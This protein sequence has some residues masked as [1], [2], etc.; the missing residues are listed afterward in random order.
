MSSADTLVA[1]R[2]R[3][4]QRIAD[5]GMGSVW[6]AW[7]ERLHRRV[8]LKQL[9]PQPGLSPQDASIATERVLREAR[10]TAR[11]HHPNAVPV[12]DVV[13]AD[14]LPCLVMQYLP[15]TSLQALLAARGPLPVAEVARIGADVAAA[16]AAAHRAGIIHRDVKPGNVLIDDSGSAK[17]TDFGIARAL[18]DA[19]LTSTG[20][21]TG[22][23]AYL[24][25]ESARGDQPTFAADVYSLGATLYAAAEGRPPAGDGSNPMA[26]LH[27]VASGR[28]DPPVRSGPLTPLLL[29]M[30]DVD[31]ARRP[32]IDTVA[33]ELGAASAGGSAPTEVPPVPAVPP[34][35]SVA[36]VPATSTMQLPLLG[37]PPAVP[38]PPP[39]RRPARVGRRWWPWLAVSAVL[40]AGL[41]LLLAT[42]PRGGSSQD[43][44]GAPSATAHSS[45]RPSAPASSSSTSSTPAA[46]TPAASSSVAIPGAAAL[47]S[48]ITDYYALL[49][50]STG[51]AWKRLTKDYQ[52][53]TTGGRKS[54]NDFWAG[55][56]AVAVS[57]VTAV[58]PN[59]VEATVTYT[60]QDGSV[61]DER[62]RFGLVDDGGGLKIDSTSVLSSTTR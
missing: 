14:G 51:E 5:G 7:D 17:L 54:Y 33:A 44:A 21:V 43:R 46:S 22:T 35:P 24:A 1:D 12:Y 2:Y 31:P 30:L 19:S 23:P 3:L 28:V 39:A 47:T 6:E 52:Q 36:P 16:L 18:G 34:V 57:D 26:V 42:L 38:G 41:V 61:V 50:G 27:R 45:H 40:L 11:L 15:S 60:R 20:L 62:T 32:S 59:T 58:G 37:A 48:A 53:G 8:A 25:P 56:R 10:L 55:M 9:H 49:P 4:V 29:R 13:D